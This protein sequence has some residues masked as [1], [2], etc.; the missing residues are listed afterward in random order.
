M[1]WTP[2]PL[3]AALAL[4]ACGPHA[5]PVPAGLVAHGLH[6]IVIDTGDAHGLS[7]L[8]LA[9]DGAVWTVA[10][11]AAAAFR[12]DLDLG[13]TPPTVKA[14]QRWPV[15][16][17][18]RG[19]ELESIAA[20]SG[21]GFL[22]GTEGGRGVNA[23]FLAPEG[24]RLVARG[25]P[26]SLGARELGVR[27]G[28]NRGLEGACAV[29]GLAVL[30]VEATGSDRTG[31][32]APLVVVAEGAAPVVRRLRLTTGTGKL[33]ALDCWRDGDR[34]RA[35]AIERHFE[36]TRVLAFELAV[37][38]GG[39][40][41]PIAPTVL[42]D[43]EPALRGSL[44]LEGLVRLPDGHLLAVVDNQYTG[45]QGPDELVWLAEAPGW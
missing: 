14:I 42:R 16:D 26:I 19:A 22:V 37:T 44:N 28:G 11:R 1:R 25:A 4:A 23:F 35:I 10:E 38:A 18:P 2:T 40:G 34:L 32:W 29:P 3:L 31:R 21:G 7:G 13:T 36:V 41:A 9:E 17:L 33:S 6:R 24:D 8:A 43:L 15:D 27:A 12:I 39:D 20:L 30:A 45:L 5:P